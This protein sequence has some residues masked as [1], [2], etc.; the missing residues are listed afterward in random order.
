MRNLFRNP[1]ILQ[2]LPSGHKI[3]KPAPLFTKIE[4][5]R[6]EELRRKY[7]GKQ[8]EQTNQNNTKETSPVQ[9]ETQTGNVD[10]KKLEEEIEK[11]G[12][13]VRK[14]KEGGAEKAKWQ[15]EVEKLLQ[16]K[17]KLAVAT[18]QPLAAPGKTKKKK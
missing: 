16:L 3:G 6:V 12:L 14:L 7:A 11:Q 8:Q 18:G 9:S 10:I 2:L 13:V 1:S 15:P 5:A 4:T 17:A